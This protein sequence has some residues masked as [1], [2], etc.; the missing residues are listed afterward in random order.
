MLGCRL[1]V[2]TVHS[3]DAAILLG[4]GTLQQS[5]QLGEQRI[6]RTNFYATLST[7]MC[8]GLRRIAQSPIR[9]RERVVR[10]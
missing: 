6:G 10:D 4:N 5:S 8:F 1:E 9:K 2:T 7:E 3:T